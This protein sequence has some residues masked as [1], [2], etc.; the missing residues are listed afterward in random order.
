VTNSDLV[1]LITA[2]ALPTILY[3]IQTADKLKALDKRVRDLE[4]KDRLEILR[5]LQDGHQLQNG[6]QK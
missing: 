6:H 3:V 5:R 1:A 2:I 4:V